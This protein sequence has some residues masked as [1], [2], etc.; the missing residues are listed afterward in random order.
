M[1]PFE[2]E[3][4]AVE[5]LQAGLRRRYMRLQSLFFI[6]LEI[7]FSELANSLKDMNWIKIRQ[8]VEAYL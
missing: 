2:V 7:L 3:D 4:G 6:A 8:N 5:F 1:P